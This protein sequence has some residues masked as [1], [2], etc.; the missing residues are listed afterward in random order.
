MGG[1]ASQAEYSRLEAVQAGRAAATDVPQE[2]PGGPS[3]HSLV[4]GSPVELVHA[5]RIHVRDG[6]DKLL[7]LRVENG[8]AIRS[9]LA[10]APG[11]TGAML[12]GRI[13]P[14]RVGAMLSGQLVVGR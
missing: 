1:A 2:Q 13:T 12:P 5:L 4:A 6:G 7:G 11:R 14:G 9:H 8:M 3:A 10:N